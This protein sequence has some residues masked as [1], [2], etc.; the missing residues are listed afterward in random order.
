MGR[1]MNQFL[2]RRIATGL[3]LSLVM[4]AGG[5]ANPEFARAQAPILAGHSDPIYT[6]DFSRDGK[7]LVTGGIDKTIMVWD[8][9]T[10]KPL[11]TMNGHTGI[12]LS[13]KISPDGKY[14]A[15]SSLDNTIKLWDMPINTPL[16]TLPVAGGGV[17]G[18]A[19]SPDGKLVIAGGADKIVRLVQI[20]DGK[21]TGELKP[22]EPARPA[23]ITKVIV[24]NDGKQAAVAYASGLI[25]L[26]NLTDGKEEG[27]LGA[28]PGP[29]ASLAYG[30]GAS[31][32]ISTGTDGVVKRWPVA[33]PA[34]RV[35]SGL[36]DGAPILRLSPNGQLL[37]TAS[38]DKQV[39]LWNFATGQL[40]RPLDAQPDAITALNFH[41]GSVILATGGQDKIVRTTDLNT[42]KLI[43][44]FAPQS[45]SITAVVFSPNGQ[46]I[47]AGDATGGIRIAQAGD[48][49]EVRT[50]AAAHPGGVAGLAHTPNGNQLISV[51][52]DKLLRVWNVADGKEVSKIALASA[53]TGLAVSFNSE[54]AA[55]ATDDKL[56][57]IYQLAD[58]KLVSTL[59][60]ATDRVTQVE[61]SRDGQK[62]LASSMDGFARVWE[63]KSGQH[64]QHFSRHSGAVS[65]AAFTADHRTVVT[66]GA[67]KSIRIEPFSMQLAHVADEKQISDVALTSNGALLATAGSDGSVKIWN[68]GNGAPVRAL[69]GGHVGAVRAVAWSANGQQVASAGSDKSV[70][71]WQENLGKMQRKETLPAAAVQLVFSG[72][73]SKLVAACEDQAIRVFNATPPNP[74]PAEPAPLEISQTLS[75]HAGAISSLALLADH[76]TL[77]SASLDGTIKS[78]SAASPTFIANFGGHSGQIYGLS[79]SPDGKM[80]ASAAYDKTIRLWDLE[81]KI[82]AGSLSGLPEAY[83]ATYSPDGKTLLVGMADKTVRLYDVEPLKEKSVYQ[84]AEYA[85]YSAVFSPDGKMLAAGGAGLGTDRKIFLWNSG[86]PQPA[87]MLEGHKDDVYRVQFNGTGTRLLT[88][89][90][91][92]QV[93]VWDVATGKAV[94][95]QKLPVVCLTGSFFPDGKRI[96]IS[97]NDGKNY[98][99]E[100]PAAAQ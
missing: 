37:A 64:M 12:V 40:I 54:Q 8:A 6:L 78:W 83:S 14:I 22:P 69:T 95:S 32:L 34:T 15:S 47:S 60:G 89:G 46:L 70:V 7:T 56:I 10:L 96:V 85:I 33:V 75:G 86:T 44:A 20:A 71:I 50:M 77:V 62:V 93:F 82:A 55:V 1:D 3:A 28:H 45:G 2:S 21:V 84:G 74:L 17:P 38:A 92:G 25:A 57:R 11:R 29:I 24:R 58:G 91:S 23:A 30:A 39:R 79:Y 65:G 72:D 16:S 53:P 9:V 13:V 61:F 43:L 18:M 76:K 81:K 31:F 49:K 66:A 42:G 99:F 87:K 100:L 5:V 4:A 19:M 52:G 68:S 80:L 51:G 88:I 73:G 48:G 41:P 97:A 63:V 67:D 59:S 36:P 94:F 26:Q 90:Y 35:I 98:L 27:I